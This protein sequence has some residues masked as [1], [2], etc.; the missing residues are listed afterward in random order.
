MKRRAVAMIVILLLASMAGLFW[1]ARQVSAYSVAT[2]TNSSDM[3]NPAD[4]TSATSVRLLT[5]E[6]ST[7]N[8]LRADTSKV[9]IYSTE[10]TPTLIIHGFGHC[11]TSQGD[12]DSNRYANTQYEVEPNNGTET[13]LPAIYNQGNSNGACGNLTEATSVA[14]G[15]S[16]AALST[17]IGHTQYYTW[18]FIASTPACTGPNINVGVNGVCGGVNSF[19]LSVSSGYIGYSGTSGRQFAIQERGTTGGSSDYNLPFAPSC[20]ATNGATATLDWSDDD[21]GDGI[22]GAYHTRNLNYKM[23]L[24]DMT[25]PSAPQPVGLTSPDLIYA[26]DGEYYPNTLNYG[27]ESAGS[28]TFKITTNHR[29]V[30]Q[31]QDVTDANGIQFQLPYDSFYYNTI[32]P[33]TLEGFKINTSNSTTGTFS[34]DTVTATPVGNN[35]PID[36]R[37]VPSNQPFY[38]YGL[39]P[40][41]QY[42]ISV[43]Q[44]A[45]S[46]T[47]WQVIGYVIC[48]AQPPNT[49]SCDDKLANAYKADTSNGFVAGTTI[50]NFT[51][52][53]NKDTIDMRWVYAP[54]P[55]TNGIKALDDGPAIDTATGLDDGACKTGA[56]SYDCDT[57]FAEPFNAHAFGGGYP[58]CRLG[59][60][61]SNPVNNLISS[62]GNYI[63]EDCDNASPSSYQLSG[64]ADCDA[65]AN[66]SDAADCTYT[67][68][69]ACF[70]SLRDGNT[71]S[72]CSA[73]SIQFNTVNGGAAATINP[74]PSLQTNSQ[75]RYV[76]FYQVAVAFSC[77]DTVTTQPD[78]V[79]PGVSFTPTVKF[80]A[81]PHATPQSGTITLLFNGT[82]TTLQ[83]TTTASDLDPTVTGRAQTIGSPGAYTATYTLNN[84]SGLTCMGPVN[85]VS[86]PYFKVQNS[87]I[88]AGGQF[89]Y[90][91]SDGSTTCADPSDETSGILAGWNNLTGSSSTG[92]GADYAALADQPIYGFASALR[93]GLLHQKSPTFLS[94]DN[95]SGS[96]SSYSYSQAYGG[97]FDPTSSPTN[98]LT[99]Q[100]PINAT[101]ETIPVSDVSNGQTNKSYV[102]TPSGGTL[103][104]Q[105]TGTITGGKKFSVFVNGNVYINE[106]IIYANANNY[107]TIGNIPSF[108]LVASGNIYISPTVTE[109]DGLYEANN[110][111]S[112]GTLDPSTGQIYDCATGTTPVA[113]SNL[114]SACNNQLVVNGS[115]VADQVNLMRT[116]GTLN[117]SQ[118]AEH[119]GSGAVLDCFNYGS[120]SPAMNSSCAAEVFNFS[121][122]FYLSQPKVGQANNNVAPYDSITSLPPIL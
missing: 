107:G 52:P 15:L 1:H 114:Y 39:T 34:G 104:L 46:R 63:F 74:E 14:V 27:N 68:M 70:D 78:I 31:W 81:G 55:S 32:C 28:A 112:D 12:T 7:G 25:D 90:T 47:N 100:K 106:N 119:Y 87:G 53:L 20:T 60:S 8:S 118:P 121:P 111:Q 109:L 45:A 69:Q 113:S 51:M 2:A 42:N 105:G 66:N 58:D 92:A 101:P 41:G 83:Y 103:T 54:S 57:L 9:T 96:D 22:E 19:S 95:Q 62:E 23:V 110:V 36:P 6:P 50:S 17:V 94:F 80:T 40:G 16:S 89:P 3:P 13:P 71:P 86:L 98:C 24:Y 11:T 97:N 49:A 79:Q 18:T 56:P 35:D 115:F 67:H 85:V 48:D 88:S 30:W 75:F 76:W 10:P 99:A 59:G 82:S 73:A 102:D 29:Y 61:T 116:Y 64:Y 4:F 117:D 26:S 72:Y 43:T 120:L 93:N 37:S 91:A 77:N 108:V 21:W 44:T 65:S 38:L 33:S 84:G 122:E 5:S